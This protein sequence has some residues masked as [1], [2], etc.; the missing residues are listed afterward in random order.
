MSRLIS[1]DISNGLERIPVPAT[2]TIDKS[3]QPPTGMFQ[4]VALVND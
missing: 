4:L 3:P 1:Q 2:N